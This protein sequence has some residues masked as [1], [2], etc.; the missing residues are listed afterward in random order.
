MKITF[1]LPEVGIGGG[2]RVVFEYA[3]RLQ[4]RGHEVNVFYPLT[5]LQIKPKFSLR[6]LAGQALG[7]IVNFKKGNKVGWFDLKA[8][9]IRVPTLNPRY[10]KLVEGL[11]P[12]ADIVVATAWQTAYLVNKLNENKG[13]KF[14]FVQH[15]EIWNAWN[16]DECWKEAEKIE[17]DPN[18]IC[19][20]MY[21]V[22]PRNEALRMVKNLVDRTYKLPL[23]KITISSWLKELIERKFSEEVE[24]LIFNGVNFDTFYKEDKVED[25]DKIRILMPYS[26][27]RWKGTE[28]GLKAFRMV[29][30]KHPDVEFVMYG[31][32]RRECIP[33][34][35]K[36]YERLLYD[37]ELRKL[38]SS[39]D[40][41]VYPSWTEGFGLPPIEAMACCCAVV[42][43]NVG[44]VPD[45]AI[46]GET[47][48]A[49]PPKNPEMLAQNII[50]LIKN[51]DERKRIAEN[52]YNYIKQFSWDKATDQLE[53]IFKKYI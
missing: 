3:N 34:W 30:E 32:K 14:Y 2:I 23:K 17:R 9:L 36:L 47:I 19:L 49:S 10:V 12:D 46:N 13:E 21:D 43:T 1:I 4:D 8:K 37:Y 51:E 39:S 27:I 26:P 31:A 5:P 44:G 22:N 11:I 16:D 33:D 38:Y 40:I 20:A 41:F 53:A 52:G 29:K 48:L 45:Y 25:R 24:T 6:S 7:V 50:R 35:I 15:Y 42:A 18:K 28:D